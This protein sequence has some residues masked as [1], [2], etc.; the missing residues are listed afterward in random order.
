MPLLLE[1]ANHI[2]VGLDPGTFFWVSIK[3]FRIKT[4]STDAALLADL[5]S[6]PQYHDTYA[7]PPG[8]GLVPDASIHGKFR[9]ECISIDSFQACDVRV[10]V[11]ELDR[12]THPADHNNHPDFDTGQVLESSVHPLLANVVTYKLGTMDESTWHEW[13]WV[14]GVNGF[15]EY[16]AIDRAAGTLNLL[17][18]SDDQLCSRVQ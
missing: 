14:V 2:S 7:A 6:H 10:A 11:D 8:E 4:G 3:C 13:G 5:I 15:H 9:R 18:A 1:F 17:V 12:W 16:V